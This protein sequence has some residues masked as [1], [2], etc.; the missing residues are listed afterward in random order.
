MYKL[1]K[2]SKKE[3]EGVHPDLVAVVERAIQIT[4]QDFSV[5]DGLRTLKEQEEYVRRGVSRTMNSK[6]LP[7]SDGFS[8]AVDLVP[9]VGR[10]VVWEWP[11]IYVVA[12]AVQEASAELRVRLRWGGCWCRLDPRRSP[13]VMVEEYV[14]K[15][16]RSGRS[17]FP[18]GPHYEL[19]PGR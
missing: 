5:V 11:P 19:M 6:H 1:G 18:D 14:A 3:L 7:Q 16:R 10:R 9:Y 13:E 12:A 2:R 8:H 17:A 15:R 4:E